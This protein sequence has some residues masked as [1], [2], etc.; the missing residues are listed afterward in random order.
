MVDIVHALKGRARLKVPELRGSPSLKA[1]LEEKLSRREEIFKASASPATGSVL[2]FFH[3]SLEA[4]A[5]AS[6][7]EGVVAKQGRTSPDNAEKRRLAGKGKPRASAFLPPSRSSSRSD[8]RASSRDAREPPEPRARPWHVMEAQGVLRFFGTS[9]KDGLSGQAARESLEARGPNAFP[10]S[11]SVSKGRILLDQFKSFP[12]TILGATALL[13][14][15]TGGTAGA[16]VAGAVVLVNGGIGYFM[17][18]R[19]ER[20]MRPLRRFVDPFARVVRQGTVREV[21]V[22]NVAPGDLVALEAGARVPADARIVE[23]RCLSIDE[24]S[25]TGESVPVLKSADPL[26]KEEAP[27]T[28]R[29][30]M[31][32]TG[33]LVT[34]GEGR[35]VVVATGRSTE[36]GRLR[37]FGDQLLPP[38]ATLARHLHQ[39]GRRMLWV[40]AAS[41][42]VLVG[43]TALRGYGLAKILETSL[44]ALAAAVPEGL[45]TLSIAA[46]A[47]NIRDM[48]R[49][50]LVVRRLRAMG[51]LGSLDTVCFDKTGTL[52]VNRM[53]VLRLHAAGKTLSVEDGRFVED[54]KPLD[55]AT[56]PD[57]LEL[58]KVGVLCNEAEIVEEE[59]RILWKGSSTEK[60][61]LELARQAGLDSARLRDEHPV[62]RK[63]SRSLHR[64]FMET[65]HRAP[66]GRTF[67]ALKGSPAEVLERCALQLKDGE[68]SPLSREDVH[69][70]ETANGRLAGKGLRVLGLAFRV[71]AEKG[72][73]EHG[74]G[75]E[76][77][78]WL[79]LAGMAD[80]LREGAEDLVAA[81]HEAGIATVVITGDQSPTA[82]AVGKRLRVSGDAPMGI[83]DSVRLAAIE[84]SAMATLARHTHVYARVTPAQ[85]FHIVQA[86]QSAGRVIAMMGDGAN[87]VLAL[88]VADMGIALGEGEAVACEAADLVLAGGDLRGTL[89]AVRDGRTVYE[90]IRK[91]L[92]F[93]MGTKLSEVLTL[94]ALVAGGVSHRASPLQAV[95]TNLLCLALVFEPPEPDILRRPPRP[96]DEPLLGAPDFERLAVDSTVLAAT[97]LG[98][99]A[100]GCL[101]YGAGS[102]AGSLAF[103]SLTVSQIL[104]ALNC[105]SQA[106]CPEKGPLPPNPFLG[107]A[108]GASLS[109]Q[110]LSMAVPGLGKFLG[111]A[112]I[113]LLDGLVMGVSALCSLAANEFMER[114]PLLTG[115]SCPFPRRPRHRAPAGVFQPFERGSVP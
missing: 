60:A 15:V 31:A 100:Y 102:R 86:Y 64:P 91:S 107:A 29:A 34:Q 5:V 46:L 58:A 109:L 74:E 72:G 36:L 76:G 93:L 56:R 69:E 33:S 26:D 14:L 110:A 49:R 82:Y 12:A 81:L 3:P 103:Q 75:S 61:L 88:K 83:M 40:G 112:S 18:S 105:R 62:V 99:G 101:R 111:M 70:I 53:S 67:R 52:T 50:G 77:F 84:P 21:A 59:G 37:T 39:A 65:L 17:E 66:R 8:L 43:V 92:R 73:E 85:K 35:A 54:G 89:V 44:S 87:D 90:N 57:L 24:S 108:L 4:E 19:S 98:T 104:Y 95:W 48:T 51:N 42:A 55:P 38:E 106:H 114:K 32:Y 78:V 71:E 28:D 63:T 9:E 10:P 13:S 41:S 96:P 20:A 27:L 113:D 30:C 115:P 16:F 7:V 23:A 1:L 97:A 79:G 68:V 6:L 2:V 80:P 45:S 11:A 47:L 94:L 25:L 22:E